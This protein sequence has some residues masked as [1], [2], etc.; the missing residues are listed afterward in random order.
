[1]R[2]MPDPSRELLWGNEV[3]IE[4]AHLRSGHFV[5][6]M[7]QPWIGTPFPLVGVL[8]SKQSQLDWMRTH[9][10]WVVV[11]LLRSEN[12]RIPAGHSSELSAGSDKGDWHG[13]LSD[14][15]AS[16][17]M[18]RR[19]GID[20]EIVEASFEMHEL[21]HHQADEL[22][23]TI[24]AGGRVDAEKARN[25]V[26]GLADELEKN[27][28]AMVWLTRIKHADQYTAQHCVNVAILS[29]GLAT[30]L[31]W[32]REQIELVGL[33]GML[34]DLGKMKLDMNILNKPGRLTDQ[35]YEHIKR[36]SRFG[37]SL[38]RADETIHP[39]IAQAVLEH[40]ERPDGNGYPLGRK[41]ENLQPM[42]ALISVVDA[43]DAITSRRPYSNP[44]SHHEALG[45]LWKERG[46][47]F[48]ATMVEAL[49]QFLGWITPGTVVRLTDNR[50]AVVIRAT[51]QHRLWP[52]VRVLESSE[53]SF[54]V[55]AMLDLAEY[56]AG[57]QGN[58]LRVAEVL[59]DDALE[60][61]LD[62]VLREQG[63]LASSQTGEDPSAD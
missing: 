40:H 35:E 28:A 21:L 3:V 44:R 48:D 10:Q 23:S 63:A 18:L 58:T 19:A 46:R 26:N 32:Q 61:E 20:E 62:Q 12:R 49:I 9:C 54:R 14:D 31:E 8:I 41:R 29:M 59:P 38:L 15:Q 33:A 13:D 16:I 34:H 11:D 7:D 56:N 30:A 42:S 45:I 55:G 27:I 47:Q 1:M 25:S 39:M 4:P 37:Y 36:H 22:I 6:R 43:Y 50:Y 52:L 57:R 51:Q 5:S 60:V 53:A 2:D 24:S 17:N